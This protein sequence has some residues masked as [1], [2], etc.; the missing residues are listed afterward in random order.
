LTLPQIPPVPKE[1]VVPTDLDNIL[2]GRGPVIL[3]SS[4]LPDNSGKRFE[5]IGQTCTV[6]ITIRYRVNAVLNPGPR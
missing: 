2:S 5:Y 6:E 3:R 1:K 4:T